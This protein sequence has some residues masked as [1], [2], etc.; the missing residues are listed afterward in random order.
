MNPGT[1]TFQ[2]FKNRRPSGAK[3]SNTIIRILE[4]HDSKLI[5][6][7]LSKTN[8]ES[9][10]VPCKPMKINENQ[11]KHNENQAHLDMGDTSKYKSQYRASQVASPR[12]KIAFL[13]SEVAQNKTC[14]SMNPGT[15]TFQ[16][17]KQQ[18][19]VG[20]QHLHYTISNS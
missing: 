2:T 8:S 10:A 20:S 19:T 4:A 13:N 7:E 5:N 17:L 6:Y 12:I 1:S 9:T 15:S 14:T 3:L 11:C 18:K 16:T